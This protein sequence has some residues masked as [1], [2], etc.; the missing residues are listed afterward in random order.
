MTVT[1]HVIN[2]KGLQLIKDFE[3]C[4]L[5]AYQDSKK[6]WTIG[7][8]HT[9]NVKS[10]D[11]ITQEKAD[12]F[13]KQDINWVEKCINSKVSTPLTSN[14][15]SALASFVYNIGCGA[16]SKSTMCRLL[17]AKLYDRASQEFK[18]WV[19]AGAKKLKGL[20]RRRQAEKQL[21][22]TP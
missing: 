6:V 2:D 19:Y 16:F 9:G 13:L 20:V 12:E 21:F 5:R 18:K 4:R 15:F 22:L 17:N 3:S 8:G 10:G 7:W 14:Q 1:S 11:V